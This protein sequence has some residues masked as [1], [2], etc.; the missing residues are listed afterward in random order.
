MDVAPSHTRKPPDESTRNKGSEQ[1]A[2]SGEYKT[3]AKHGLNL[4]KLSIHTTREKDN[5]ERYHTDKLRIGHIIELQAE[6]VGTEE[7]TYDKKQQKGGHAKASTG[8]AHSNA[9]K[10]QNRTYKKYVSL[11][12]HRRFI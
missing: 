2:Y 8:F 9:N 6:A 3:R 10:Q 4:A 11:S 5:A 7:H 1:Y 12:N